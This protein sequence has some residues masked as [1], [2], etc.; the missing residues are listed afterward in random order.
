MSRTCEIQDN[1]FASSC[2]SLCPSLPRLCI[3]LSHAV[4]MSRSLAGRV[5]RTFGSVGVLALYKLQ[6]IN[7]GEKN[8]GCQNTRGPGTGD[9]RCDTG[10]RGYRSYLILQH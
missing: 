5:Y 4:V 1:L 3:P 8:E 9:Q 6:I 2:L 10:E 7:G